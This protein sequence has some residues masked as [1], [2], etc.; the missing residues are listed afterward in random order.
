MRYPF[1][2]FSYNKPSINSNARIG[3]INTPHGAF[4]T[5]NFMFCGTK[6]NIKSISIN[7]AKQTNTQIILSNT[8]HL[9]VQPGS[10]II[11]EIG[12]IQKFIGWHGPMFTDSGGFQI[13]SFGYGSVAEEIKK[14]KHV[15]LKTLLN[16]SEEGVILKSYKNGK[17]YLLSPE[18]SIKIQEKLEAD[19]I[20]TLDECTPYHMKK[21]YTYFAMCRSHRW[22]MR[23]LN[24]FN[25]ILCKKQALYGVIQGGIYKNLRKQS[26]NFVNKNNFFGH[27]IGGSLG[28]NKK[29]MYNTISLT[30]QNLYVNRPIHLLGVGRI[31]NI[32][33]CIKMGVDTFDC[34]Q[35]TRLARHGRALVKKQEKEYINLF[36]TCY[37]EDNQPIEY[38]CPC[39]S[40]NNY[41]RAYLHHLLKNKEI[42][43][44]TII[45]IHNITFINLLLNDIRKGIKHNILKKIEKKWKQ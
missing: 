3:I 19:L 11:S 28:A 17:E 18:Q 35:P 14:K 2:S 42:I 20:V 34:V 25:K 44:S 21:N 32:F 27:A 29:Q 10:K 36:N 33:S 24:T 12:G 30:I 23:S 6:G 39:T 1:F 22:A 15:M 4:K 5:P 45:T 37:K 43:V 26:S 41:T 8:Y 38:Q 40:C 16:I 13:F 7:E 31:K 9:M